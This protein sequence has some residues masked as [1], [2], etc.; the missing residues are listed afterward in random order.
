MPHGPLA[1]LIDWQIAAT[2]APGPRRTAQFSALSFD[3]SFHEMFT[4]W[5]QGGTLVLVSEAVRR[6][7]GSLLHLLAERAIEQLFLPFVALQ[8][9]ADEAAMSGILPTALREVITAGE[10]LQATTAVRELF[11]RLPGCRLVNA[12]GPTETHVV[13]A[14]TLPESPDTWPTLPPIGQLVANLWAR[15]LDASQQPV[16]PGTPGELYFGGTG[17]ARGYLG[18]PD[19]TA[20]RF[21]PDPQATEPGARVYRTGDLARCL[22]DGVIEFLGRNDHQ[23]KV[24]GFRVEP[25]EIEAALA[26]HPGVREAAVVVREVSGPGDRRLVG[27]IVPRGRSAAE[28]GDA[29]AGELRT[30]LGSLLPEYMVP[31]ALVPMDTF[32]LTPSGKLDRRNLPAPVAARPREAALSPPRGPVQELLAGIWAE[33][34]GLERVGAADHFFELGGHSLL[35]TRV[36]SRLRS[37]FDIAMPLRTL[38]EAPRLDDLAAQVEAALRAGASQLA[39]PLV[40]VTREGTLLPLSFAQQRLWFID[41]LEPASPS[42]NIPAAVLLNGELDRAALA[43]CFER[44]VARHEI[45]RTTFDAA[46]EEPV[47]RIDPGPFRS[48]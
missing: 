35:A 27:Y 12:Y 41:Q 5:S 31:W 2:T 46:G 15:V 22:P 26:L 1:N 45:L 38:F 34:L 6:D 8:Q 40:P 17:L 24:R 3:A 19:S 23:V 32:P 33:V 43:A 9:L 28:A 39:P 36:M 14:F 37:A 48:P 47:Q 13:T 16:L 30:F 10:Q 42:Y 44:I 11:R 18:R 20:E 29:L 4:A 21:L 7:A 25:G